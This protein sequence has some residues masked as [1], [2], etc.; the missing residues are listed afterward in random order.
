MAFWS[1]QDVNSLQDVFFYLVENSRLFICEGRKSKM[2][3]KK[4][5]KKANGMDTH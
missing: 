1:K 3:A 2:R 5:K 4:K